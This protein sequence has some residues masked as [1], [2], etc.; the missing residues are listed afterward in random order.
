MS[1]KVPLAAQIEKVQ[2]EVRYAQEDHAER[3][4]PL[5]SAVLESLQLLARLLA[6]KEAATPAGKGESK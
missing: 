3:A 1:E 5:W 4:L 6:E 2:R